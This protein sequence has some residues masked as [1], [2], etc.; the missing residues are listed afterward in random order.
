MLLNWSMFHEVGMPFSWCWVS[1]D[2][3]NDE[4]DYRD[5]LRGLSPPPFGPS[6]VIQRHKGLVSDK[7]LEVGQSAL[8]ITEAR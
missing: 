2:L 1:Q 4:E 6:V 5:Y 7:H 3:D 8:S